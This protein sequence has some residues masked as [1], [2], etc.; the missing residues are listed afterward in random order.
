MIK[1]NSNSTA[2]VYDRVEDKSLRFPDLFVCPKPGFKP[3]KMANI[4]SLTENPWHAQEIL[5]GTD[6]VNSQVII[7]D[8]FETSLY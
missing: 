1:Y 5:V 6:K 2:M 8:I 4:S 3:E 7:Y